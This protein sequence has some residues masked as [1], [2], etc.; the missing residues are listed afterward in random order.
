MG[1]AVAAW[2]DDRLND[3]AAEFEPV[4][5]QLATLTASTTHFEHL[6]TQMEPL[7]AQIAVLAASV[8]RLT[9][10]NRTLRGEVAAAQRQ[11]VQISWVL[12]GALMGA[13][14]AIANALL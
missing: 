4:K 1:K 3:L 2:T 13:G 5:T 9:D 10:E 6:A 12:M 7:P 14:A 11:L 8:E